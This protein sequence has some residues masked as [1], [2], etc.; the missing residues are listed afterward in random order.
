[1]NRR[2]AARPKPLLFARAEQQLPNRQRLSFH[3]L[4]HIEEDHLS[5]LEDHLR[6]ISGFLRS[7]F[8][9]PFTVVCTIIA[10]VPWQRQR[11]ALEPAP[12]GATSRALR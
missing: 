7:R 2:I 11:Q 10:S 6:Q 4:L 5:I 9:V 3:R 1:V 12:P 8:E